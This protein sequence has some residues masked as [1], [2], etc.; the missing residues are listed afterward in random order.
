MDR[1]EPVAVWCHGGDSDA[2]PRP[3]GRLSRGFFRCGLGRCTGRGHRHRHQAH[4][5]GAGHRDEH[6]CG[7]WA[8]DP[9][10]GTYQFH[11]DCAVGAGRVHAHQRTRADRDRDAGHDLCRGQLLDRRVL[12]GRYA[13]HRT[14]QLAERQGGD[15]PQS[16][17]SQ[18]CRGAA[19]A[20]G[21]AVRLRLD[22]W[23]HQADPECAG[24]GALRCGRGGRAV[25]HRR[26]WFQPCRERHGQPADRFH[27]RG[28]PGW[29]RLGR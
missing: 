4:L 25:V 17:R 27:G 9:G 18:P 22:G 8:G 14:G 26:R 11:R 21:D 13:A 23:H 5:H 28:A 16:L 2:P 19:R 20:A 10:P 1:V 15:R 12:S 29:L 3:G 6:H 24:P 7:H